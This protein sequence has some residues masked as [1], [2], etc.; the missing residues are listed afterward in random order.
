MGKL[1]AIR[2]SNDMEALIQDYAAF[3]DVD[4]SKAIRELITEGFIRASHVGQLDRLMT[5]LREKNPDPLQDMINCEKCGKVDGLQVYHI[6]G[7]IRNLDPKNLVIIC[8][9][10]YP[11]LTRFLLR[12]DPR[13]RF[14][15]WFLN[16]NV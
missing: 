1:R 3:K 15:A 5:G 9:D 12:Y 4:V 6:D 7:N 11:S 2:L 14:T 10:C 16:I 13:E 8:K